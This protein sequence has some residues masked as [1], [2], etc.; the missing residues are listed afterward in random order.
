MLKNHY[1]WKKAALQQQENIPIV[2]VKDVPEYDAFATLKNE[3]LIGKHHYKWRRH[4]LKLA[5]KRK[6][7]ATKAAKKEAKGGDA[8]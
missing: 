2:N 5:Y 1:Q 8:E 6:K 7:E 3:K 4:N